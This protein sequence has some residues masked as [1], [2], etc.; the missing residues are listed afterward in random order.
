MEDPEQERAEQETGPRGEAATKEDA[1]KIGVDV[2]HP[3]GF[4]HTPKWNIQGENRR[5]AEPP[6]S[7]IK[8]GHMESRLCRSEEQ[9]EVYGA[10]EEAKGYGT[11]CTGP[12]QAQILPAHRAVEAGGKGRQQEPKLHDQT[13]PKAQRRYRTGNEVSEKGANEWARENRY[14]LHARPSMTSGHGSP[15]IATAIPSEMRMN[16]TGGRPWSCRLMGSGEQDGL[17]VPVP[18]GGAPPF[19]R[20]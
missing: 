5:Q 19:C 4:K 8:M 1:V 15:R 7:K 17:A 10:V 13:T 11:P 3:Q 20:R 9:G 12:H 14:T 6:T 18:R 16:W 2:R